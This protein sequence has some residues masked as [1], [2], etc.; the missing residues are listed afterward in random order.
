MSEYQI[1][2]YLGDGLYNFISRE[3]ILE[4]NISFEK[5]RVAM[6][7]QCNDFM[8]AVGIEIGLVLHKDYFAT[9]DIYGNNNPNPWADALEVEF[10]KIYKAN[11]FDA[12][13]EYF[14]NKVLP[15]CPT[16]TVAKEFTRNKKI[17]HIDDIRKN[18]S[19]LQ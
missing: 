16:L 7:I 4:N 18:L 11:G 8:A 13:K 5:R 3:V 6:Y 10:Y 1:L 14:K 15:F 2:E 19:E 12:A 9:V 17:P